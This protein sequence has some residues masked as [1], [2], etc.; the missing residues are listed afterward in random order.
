MTADRTRLRAVVIAT[1]LTL[2]M[3]SASGAQEGRQ[4]SLP[5]LYTADVH[6]SSLAF[7]VLHVGITR[8]RGLFNQWNAALTWDGDD[9]TRS[10]VTVVI[11]PASVDTNSDFRDRDLRSDNFFHADRFPTAVLQSTGI[12]HTGDGYELVGR[13]RIKDRVR[14]VRIPAASLGDRMSET[15]E[16]RGFEGAFT[17]VRE[18]FGVVN[19]GNI[20]ERTGAIGKEV[21]IQIQLSAFRLKPEGRSYRD[22]DDARSVGAV[23]EEVLEAEGIEAAVARYRTALEDQG[24]SVEMGLPELVTLGSRLVLDGRAA[25]A[26]RILGVYVEHRPEDAEGRFWLGEMLAEAGE[27]DA[28]LEQ[29]HRALDLDPLRADAAERIRY[30]TDSRHRALLVAGPGPE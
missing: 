29:Y 30:L 17:V 12:R 10:S 15:S 11:D 20:L 21:E 5:P 2:L 22:R 19:E 1:A 18:E 7:T 16:R 26:A 6:H 23:L 3:P 8:V 24:Q 9:P 4:P 25:D 28:A 13:L 27:G 14:T